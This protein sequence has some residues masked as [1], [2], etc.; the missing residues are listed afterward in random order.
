MDISKSIRVGLAMKN[1]K[2][3]WLA[4]EL[5]VSRAYISNL[6]NGSK[7]PGRAQIEEIASAFNV[8]VSEFIMWGEQ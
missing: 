6:C 7:I 1:V 3:K 4:N 5:G 8:K 2:Q